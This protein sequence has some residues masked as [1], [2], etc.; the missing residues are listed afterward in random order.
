MC[1]NGNGNL[2]V[3]LSGGTALSEDECAVMTDEERRALMLSRPESAYKLGLLEGAAI[4]FGIRGMADA[5][6]YNWVLPYVLRIEPCWT[7]QQG[8]GASACCEVCGSYSR[9][10][11]VGG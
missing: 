11:N 3:K 5:I 9:C 1:E 8:W 7:A 10:R 2:G 6:R 4:A